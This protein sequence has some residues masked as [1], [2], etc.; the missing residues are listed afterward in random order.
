MRRLRVG[1]KTFCSLNWLC[2]RSLCVTFPKVVLF[3]GAISPFKYHTFICKHLPKSH[4]L[5]SVYTRQPSSSTI[6]RILSHQVAKHWSTLHDSCFTMNYVAG[7]FN[8]FQFSHSKAFR[9]F[10]GFFFRSICFNTSTKMKLIGNVSQ[11][12]ELIV[13][14]S[15][16]KR[17]DKKI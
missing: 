12:I 5:I 2:G 17:S 16:S 8:C 10:C 4:I 9:C 3:K 13:Q 15:K 14:I 1:F 6:D 7:L 11:N